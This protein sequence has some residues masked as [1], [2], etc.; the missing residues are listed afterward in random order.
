MALSTE[1]ITKFVKVTKDETKDNKG[2]TV[3]GEL[4]KYNNKDY[5][6]ID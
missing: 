6:K 2:S 4:L 1:L 3:Y 5:V